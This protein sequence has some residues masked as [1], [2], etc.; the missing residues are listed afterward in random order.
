MTLLYFFLKKNFEWH[1]NYCFQILI[2]LTF[3]QQKILEVLKKKFYIPLKLFNV[4]GA[5]FWSSKCFV[6]IFQTNKKNPLLRVS[7]I[8]KYT[9]FNW[10][11]KIHQIV[12]QFNLEGTFIVMSHISFIFYVSRMLNVHN[13]VQ[14]Q[15]DIFSPEPCLLLW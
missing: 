6:C 14:P 8:W 4:S 15:A 2:Y 12:C 5:D 10:S 9:Q 7:S 1:K 13:N 3:S 11:Q